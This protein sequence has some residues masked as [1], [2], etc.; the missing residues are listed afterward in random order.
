MHK[1]DSRRYTHTNTHACTRTNALIPPHTH[2]HTHAG[3]QP[4]WPGQPPFSGWPGAPAPAPAPAPAAPATGPN[5]EFEEDAWEEMYV[6]LSLCV[7]VYMCICSECVHGHM[8]VCVIDCGCM[9]V[10][11]R[12]NR[13]WH[14][15][16]KK[17]SCQ[18]LLPLI[19][20]TCQLQS[21]A[22]SHLLTAALLPMPHTD[23]IVKGLT[24][25]VDR[26][27]LYELFSPFG[28]KA[29]CATLQL[30]VF[31]IKALAP[32]G[33]GRAVQFCSKFLVFHVRCSHI[34]KVGWP[35]SFVAFS[36]CSSFRCVLRVLK[37]GRLQEVRA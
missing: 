6:S 17:A 26:L 31:Y 8:C 30:P 34:L 33:G 15:L 29:G 14:A 25:D 9:W 35:C 16:F 28:G 3:G 1:E 7:C 11:A 2:T 24:P 5:S 21:K 10:L 19:L 36:V 4:Q 22:K 20:L 37:L 12:E 23:I 18:L 27:Q 32:F 13:G